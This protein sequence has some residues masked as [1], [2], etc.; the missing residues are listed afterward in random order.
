MDFIKEVTLATVTSEDNKNARHSTTENL[1]LNETLLVMNDTIDFA[2]NNTFSYNY[3]NSTSKA[4]SFNE[5][6]IENS[7]NFSNALFKE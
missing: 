4:Y 5:T 7:F 1:A 3:V 6:T 2:Y